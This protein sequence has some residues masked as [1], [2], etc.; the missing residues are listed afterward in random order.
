MPTNASP[1]SSQH[2]A[3]SSEIVVANSAGMFIRGF[4][5]DLLPGK[6]L[7]EILTN[8]IKKVGSLSTVY[9]R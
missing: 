2:S 3:E 1:V 7:E 8:D 9:D 6:R 4:T 5:K